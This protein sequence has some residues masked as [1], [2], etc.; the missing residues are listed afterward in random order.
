MIYATYNIVSEKEAAEQDHIARI[1]SS[2]VNNTKV[3]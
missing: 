2:L 1:L 3:T